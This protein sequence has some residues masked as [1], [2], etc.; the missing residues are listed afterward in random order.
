MTASTS[1]ILH[2]IRRS[3]VT[4]HIL[5]LAALA[6]IP[7]LT[8]APGKMPSDTKLYL[9]FNPARLTADA[10]FAW[11]SRQ[12]AGWVPHQTV[13]YLWPSG[14]WYSFFSWVGAPDWVAQRLWLA[15]LLVLG[16]LGARWAA[17]LLGLSATG[18]LIAALFYQLSP[19]VLPYVSRTSAMLLPWAGLGWLI[20][21]TIRAAT[22]SRWRDVGLFGLVM[23]TVAAPN[24]TAIL[25]IAPAPVLWLGHAAWG[26]II[27]W[28]RAAVTAAKIGGI[29]ILMSLWWIAMLSVQGRYGADV[30]GYSESLQAVSLTSASTEVLRGMGY[31][32]MYVRDPIGF[33]T[34][35]GFEYMSSGRLIAVSFAVLG[36]G[37]LGIVCTKWTSRRYA[38]LLVFVGVVLAVGVHPI[39]NPSPLMSPFAGNSRSSLALALRSS[40]RALPLST[41]GIAL[42]AGAF[43]TALGSTRF[44]VRHIVPWLAGVLAVANLPVLFNGGLVDANLVRDENPPAAWSQAAA[45]LDAAPAGY[46][47]FELPGTE[48]G[49]F[50]WGYTVD[51]PLPGL[52]TKPLVTRDLLPLGSPAAM[53][54]IYA[55]DD[56]FQ[57]G[58]A[59]VAGLAP[60]ARLL[61]V[62]TIWLA[63][64]IAF[65]RFRT[66]RPELT[67][68]LFAS[69]AAGLGSAIAYGTPAVNVPILAMTDE[70]SI[71][72]ATVGA[73]LAPVELI[74]V[75]DP[76]PVMRTKTQSVVVAGSGDGLVD[77]AAAGLLTGNELIRYSADI[78]NGA[79]TIADA[80]RVIVTDSNRDRAHQW[81]SAQDVTGFTE[82]G[83]AGSGVLR[84]D[85]AD[86]RTPVFPNATSN[87]MTVSD[88]RGPVTAAASSYGEPSAYLPEDRPA[89]AI[90][91]NP[92][93]AWLVGRRY[94]ADGEYIRLDS[95]SPVST[96]TLV[97]P[98][99]TRNRWITKIDIT[100]GSSTYGADLT[101]ES[102]TIGG[103]R[104]ALRT[105][106]KRVTIT[107]T[108]TEQKPLAYGD[109][110]DA[111]GFAE[112]ATGAGPTEEII[113]VPSNVLAK[114]GQTQPLDIVLTRLRTRATNRWRG[115]PEPV[116]ARSFTLAGDRNFTPTV[117]ARLDQRAGDNVIAQLIGWK[118][119]TASRRLSGVP[120]MGGWAATDGDP[121][122]SW[123]S[124]FGQAVGSSLTIPLVAISTLT[125]L[126][127][128]QP[129]SDQF[130]RITEVEVASESGS[131]IVA[132]T[133]PDADGVGT[134]SFPAVTGSTLTLTVTATDGASTLDRRYGDT[135]QLPVAISEIDGDGI[136]SA[137]LPQTLNT[138]CRDDLVSIDGSGVGVDITGTVSDMFAG[139]PADVVTCA[140][141]SVGLGYGE[142]IVRSAP[143]MATALDIDRVVLRSATVATARAGGVPLL[144][145][146]A[147]A[148]VLAQS[149]TSRTVRVDP[150]PSG[151]WFV[152]GEGFNNGWAASIGGKSLGAPQPVDGGFN[153]W[154]LPPSNDARVI[155]LGFR[156]QTALTLGLV[157]SGLG[158]LVCLGLVV[159]D[160]KRRDGWEP[161][162][163]A[164]AVL[165]GHR[166]TGSPYGLRTPA[167]IST[168]VATVAGIIVITPLWGLICGM[169]AFACCFVLR[170]PRLLGYIAVGV[171]TYIGV[172]MV[173]RVSTLHPFANAGWP[174]VFEDLHHLGLTVIV[175]LVSAV[176]SHRSR[177]APER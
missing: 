74:P 122:T 134:V 163:P 88:Q 8:A 124:P 120:A 121:T 137:A 54:L 14:P 168:A 141:K 115:D 126:R 52:T 51:P 34:T 67:H 64:D 153:G 30:L 44:R 111:V 17:R 150:C 50:R 108:A 42:G 166:T 147:K 13:S 78:A 61:G 170:R 53:D 84:L 86:Q 102:R 131:Q 110:L 175:L 94:S 133:A 149:P 60:I 106:S 87:D 138:G 142:H 66:P 159:A 31:W 48:F 80:S 171:A 36:I 148:T 25:M 19:Y 158:V 109:G 177:R 130:A 1:V 57:E 89:M 157:L 123:V 41:L 151:C 160:R 23:A 22:R 5:V 70:Q 9:Y 73:A 27:T 128:R 119:T 173:R 82:D 144:P 107:I 85:S 139:R 68:A 63:N 97:Q 169:L 99:D 143:G 174:G 76:Q 49:A 59:E 129:I 58:T 62:D 135:V 136:V 26:R 156:G 164:M 69:G 140:A 91:G 33:A 165:W 11:D 47:V 20:G 56:R 71:S 90:D 155:E 16:G 18:A 40:T 3:S 24:A 113:R 39:D 43:V 125:T 45:A 72:G 152:F 95:A 77:A 98:Q 116:L 176:V 132:V 93:T 112:I 75:T 37:L 29:S 28:R 103:Q 21:L 117:T 114:V 92:A 167:L 118:G 104:I 46:R 146:N 81:R 55:L 32:L 145:T 127:I 172:V 7:A 35:A 83:S 100:D 162:I 161:D 38:A 15:T 101:N 96:L 4:L 12:F 2:R 65:E 154:L 105:P 10:R 79:T 6:Y